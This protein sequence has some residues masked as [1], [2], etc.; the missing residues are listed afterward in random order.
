[1]TPSEAPAQN[2]NQGRWR[3]LA[4]TWS[5]G[6]LG[7]LFSF[8]LVFVAGNWLILPM[9]TRGT[10]VV[11][12][13]LYGMD[14]ADAKRLVERTGLVFVND[15]SDFTTDE[16]VPVDHVV[17]QSPTADASIKKGRSVR[18]TVSRGAPKYVV[19]NVRGVSLSNAR[20]RL[21]QARFMVGNVSYVLRTNED[22]SEPYVQE[23]F[24]DAGT[25]LQKDAQVTLV[26]SIAPEMPDLV[27]RDAGDATRTLSAMGIPLG[28]ITGELD[29]TQ[30]PG[31]ILR[32]SIPPGTRVF[33]GSRVDL[34]T[35]EDIPPATDQ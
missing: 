13:N 35:N 14:V 2:A 19:P 25:S 12:P 20:L 26:V 5:A 22:F 21:E 28:E 11:V 7:A 34:V 10:D 32:Q 29:E 17:M 33:A 8:V 4:T 31:A 1:M 23:Q 27:G 3:H 24:P 30:A 16:S 18:V 15:P 6:L 9:I